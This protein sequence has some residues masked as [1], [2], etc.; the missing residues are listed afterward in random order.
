MRDAI[1]SVS[2]DAGFRHT[3]KLALETAGFYVISVSVESAARFEIQM[4]RCGAMVLCHRLNEDVHHSLSKEFRKYC[5]DGIVVGIVEIESDPRISHHDISVKHSESAETLIEA[6]LNH[7]ATRNLA[8][9][10]A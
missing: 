2:P 8:V 3:R 1:L 9:R 10:A 6:L 5:A 7:P 4:G